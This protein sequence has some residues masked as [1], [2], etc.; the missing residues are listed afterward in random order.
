VSLVEAIKRDDLHIRCA[1]EDL[2]R[3]HQACVLFLQSSLR[4][5]EIQDLYFDYCENE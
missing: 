3:L 4:S 1:L 2:D 5:S